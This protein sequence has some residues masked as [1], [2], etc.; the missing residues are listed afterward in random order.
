MRIPAQAINF[1][2]SILVARIL[3]PRD[4]GIMGITMMLIGYANLFTN[5]GFIEAIIQKN[6]HDRK[7]LNSIFTCNLFISSLLTGGFYFIAGMVADFFQTPECAMVIRVMSM[8]F[9]IT[10]LPTVPNAVL[11]RDMNFKVL[12]FFDLVQSVLMSLITLLLAYRGFGYWALVY[13][14]IVPLAVISVLLCIKVRYLPFL[15]YNNNL[16]KQVYDFGI[17][18]FFGVQLLFISQHV[19][20][21]IVGKWLGPVQ[22]G[23][24]DKALSLGATPY[25]SLIMN[26]N[27]V[28]FS[29]FSI[30][31]RN[32]ARL[33]ESFKKSVALL[34][35]VNL[36]IY[37]GLI[38]IAPQF[39]NSLLGDKWL[40]MIIPFQIILMGFIFRSFMGITTSLNVGVGRY[41][42]NAIRSFISLLVFTILCIMFRNH[43]IVAISLCFMAFC[44]LNLALLTDLSCRSIGLEISDI[45]QAMFPGMVSS[46]TMYLI[47]VTT[48]HFLLK[49]YSI[50]NMTLIIFIGA[51]TY[52]LS[53]ALN[54]SSYA[55][56][57][58]LNLINDSRKIFFRG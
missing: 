19:D 27:S 39:V 37:T 30:D 7:T 3:M 10:S 58:K 11:R 8:V 29:S 25:N 9:I 38:V 51:A 2:I 17:W 28:M 18:N 16:M 35:F 31:K 36:P 45:L 20:R 5:F 26:I 52:I 56:E 41:K 43:S 6:I 14:Q 42:D 40:P 24:Y 34:S 33:R 23:F 22:L 15:Y 13:G 48:S 54:R 46:L 55:R 57:F 50:M 4:F 44:I 21:F 32:L 49:T 1:A 53:I 47:A 12:A